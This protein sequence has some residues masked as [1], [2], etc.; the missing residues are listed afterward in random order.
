MIR[1][2]QTMK[3]SSGFIITSS[4]LCLAL[5]LGNIPVS[6]AEQEGFFSWLF[7]LERRKGVKP[8]TDASYNEECGACHFA[9]QPGLLPEASWRQLLTRQALEK[10]FGENAELDEKV[11]THILSIAV[12]DSADKS[13]YKRSKKIMASLPEG[14]V[15]LR[16]TK[17][18]YFHDKHEEVY[19]DVVKNSK[20]IKSMSLCD[21]CHQ[22]AKQGI[23]DDDTVVIPDY[24]RW[25]W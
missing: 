20:K 7:T 4:A 18:P 14:E 10:H 15:P 25:T 21:Q 11:R 12:E 3:K 5:L 8:V 16:I 22:K 9:Y 6:H 17:V 1:Q 2:V 24:G 19:E 23:Y 13:R